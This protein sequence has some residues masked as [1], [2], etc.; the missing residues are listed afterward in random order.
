MKKMLVM[1]L[2]LVMAFTAVTAFAEAA[3]DKQYVLDK[4]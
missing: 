3:S 4:G 1:L 2:T